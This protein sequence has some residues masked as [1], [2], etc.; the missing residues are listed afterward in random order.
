MDPDQPVPMGG[1]PWH[2]PSA[3]VGMG[4]GSLDST[5]PVAGGARAC[6]GPGSQLNSKRACPWN[7]GLLLAPGLWVKAV[8]QSTCCK[9]LWA[10]TPI[11]LSIPWSPRVLEVDYVALTDPLQVGVGRCRKTPLKGVPSPQAT[12]L[13]GTHQRSF[14]PANVASVPCTLG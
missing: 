5:P 11:S 7:P 1:H 9:E 14:H 12:P 2:V 3:H 4:S 8:A 10:L 6:L 13:K